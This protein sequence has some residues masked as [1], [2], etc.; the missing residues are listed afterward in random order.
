MGIP[1]S[2]QNQGLIQIVKGGNS[3]L[4]GTWI[5][6]YVSINLAQWCSPRFAVHVA[7]WV[8]ELM[9]TGKV[10][11]HSGTPSPQMLAYTKANAELLENFGITGNAKQLSLNNSLK[12]EFGYD[13]LKEWG[14]TY[15]TAE[16]QQQ[17]LTVSDIAKRL[18]LKTREINPLLIAEGLQTVHRDHKNRVYYEL[19]EKGMSYAV[20]QDT[21]KK[22]KTTGEPVRS[23]KWYESV[24]GLLA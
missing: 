22:H 3:Q 23:V 20:Y 13:A 15:L 5:H 7:K 14:L 2:E 17:L 6:P 9:T 1:I 11:L 10:E 19:T 4:Q 12:K 18:D 21:S 16:V 8:F 24:T